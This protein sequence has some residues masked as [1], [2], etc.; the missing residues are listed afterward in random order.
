[1][2][3]GELVLYVR[4]VELYRDYAYFEGK[5]RQRGFEDLL[6]YTYRIRHTGMAHSL[7]IW[8][9]LPYIDSTVKLPANGAYDVPA[10]K[11]PW[12]TSTPITPADWQEILRTGIARHQLNDF[13]KVTFSADLVPAAPLKLPDVLTGN[14]G[15]YYRNRAIFYTWAD[16]PPKELS[17][18]IKGGL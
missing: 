14:P 1:A 6:R 16:T 17:L 4:Y 9:T 13:T 8:R 7:G 5:D 12:K 3:I 18:T 11:N 10:G 15:L 2:R